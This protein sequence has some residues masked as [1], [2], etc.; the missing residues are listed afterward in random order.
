MNFAQKHHTDCTHNLQ[1]VVHVG[2]SSNEVLKKSIPLLQHNSGGGVVFHVA[3]F[4]S[5]DG[6]I[7]H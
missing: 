6:L 1:F 7:T 2:V 4:P 5:H 3:L